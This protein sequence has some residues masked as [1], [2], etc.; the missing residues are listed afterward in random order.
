MMFMIGA[1]FQAPQ[2]FELLNFFFDGHMVF[3]T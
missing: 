2:E 1:A 3:M